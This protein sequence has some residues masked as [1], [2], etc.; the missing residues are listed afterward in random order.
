[1]YCPVV[2]FLEHADISKIDNE[3]T[4]YRESIPEFWENRFL[5]I[6]LN[7]KSFLSPSITNTLITPY[8]IS[9]SG[10]CGPPLI[11][12]DMTTWLCCTH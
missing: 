11:V 12:E 7:L 10:V 4:V 5:Y 6:Y 8:L 3:H 1:M 9:S 2:T